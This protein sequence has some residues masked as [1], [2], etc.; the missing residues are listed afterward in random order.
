MRNVSDSVAEH[1]KTH[2][3]SSIIP[4]PLENSPIYAIIWEVLV[5]SDRS[6]VYITWRM[7]LACLINGVMDTLSECVISTAFPWQHS[8]SERT[9][10]LRYTYIAFLALSDTLKACLCFM[11]LTF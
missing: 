5:D 7:R 1:I 3:S 9:S 4:S 6:Q 11:V 10:V 8:L 2:N